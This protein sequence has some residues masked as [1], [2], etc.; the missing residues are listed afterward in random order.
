MNSTEV[1]VLWIRV[2]RFLNNEIDLLSV[3]SECVSCMLG[4]VKPHTHNT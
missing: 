1:D 4:S 2:E 3:E